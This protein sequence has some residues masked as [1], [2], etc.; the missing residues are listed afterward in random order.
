MGCQQICQNSDVD[1][2]Y[3]IAETGANNNNKKDNFKSSRNANK[4]NYISKDE[5]NVSNMNTNNFNSLSYSK[6]NIINAG[7]RF[8]CSSNITEILALK[9][10]LRIE[11]KASNVHKMV[12]IWIAKNTKITFKVA[13]E[14]GFHEHNDLFDSL[15]CPEFEEK[16]NDLNFGSLVGYVPG[17]ELFTIVDGLTL[18]STKDGPLYLFQNNGLY[19]VNPKGTLELEITGGTP[20]SIYDIEKKLGWDLN[21]L[22]TSIPEM[23][24]DEVSLLILLN[25]A[26]TNP[27]LFA[28]QYLNSKTNVSNI[29]NPSTSSQQAE[30]ELEEALCNLD[31]LP[32]LYCNKQVYGVS[33]TH[34]EDLGKNK[35]AG[36]HSS[37]G[38]DLE[39][40]LKNG[41]ISTKVFAEN[42]IFGYND[43]LEIIYRLLIDEDNENRSQ[44]K[45][46]LS[47]DFNMVG[48]AIEPHPGEYCWSCIQDFILDSS[49]TE[50]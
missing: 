12:P 45:I 47:M 29:N 44:R 23:K 6:N 41:G 32:V 49:S 43:P 19:S 38:F 31:P 21:Y 16:P 7:N 37:E 39:E 4:N 33:K 1:N 24:E 14:W 17:D 2:K 28:S 35:M 34:A 27:K 40:R 15:G 36:H 11:I 25:K 18:F 22:D 20:M 5:T 26:R 8:S 13:G 50:N 30:S 42:C 9:D 46:I 48:I 10:T 3:I